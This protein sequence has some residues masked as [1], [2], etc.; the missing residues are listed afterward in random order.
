MSA[1]L[2][3]ELPAEPGS[4]T[5]ARQ[6][7]EKIAGTLGCDAEAVK[8]AVSEIVGNAV[9]HGYERDQP[10][11]V[12]LVL[13]RVLRGRLIVTVA[14]RGGGMTPKIDSPGLGL[15]LPIVSQLAGDVRIDSDERGAAVS[16]SFECAG[17]GEP[18]ADTA[19]DAGSDLGAELKRA[20][21]ALRG[22]GGLAGRRFRWSRE[23]A[24]ALHA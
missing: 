13:A 5:R 10:E 18:G 1:N 19:E 22:G 11:G 3:L 4:V 2:R 21:R 14:D 24:V 17:A 6:A 20:R 23:P 7:L 8:I 9:V 16:M 12:V 15:G